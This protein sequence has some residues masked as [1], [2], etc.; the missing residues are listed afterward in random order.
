V[1]GP[2]FWGTYREWAGVLD[3]R[4]EVGPETDGVFSCDD[5]CGFRLCAVV[6]GAFVAAD[7]V[8]L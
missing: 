4:V 6:L 2:V 3:P 1:V 8:A 7:V 5:F